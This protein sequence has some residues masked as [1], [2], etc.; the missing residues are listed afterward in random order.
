MVKR[1]SRLVTQRESNGRIQRTPERYASQLKRA[2]DAILNQMRQPEWG[3]ACGMLFLH[4]HIT[5]EQFEAAKRWDA[6]AAA[7]R[8]AIAV[9]GQL[10]AAGTERGVSQHPP[11]PDS[12]EGS[13]VAERDRKAVE[14]FKAA[15]AVLVGVGLLAVAVVR[16][17]VEDGE[18]PVSF[19]QKLAFCRGC[20]ALSAHWGLTNQG[21]R[22]VR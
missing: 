8:K 16:A 11:D 9:P 21:K 19:E 15:H 13:I 3:T 22:N 5:A 1:K 14:R 4:E 17:T 20:D 6:C 18:Y 10:K 2:R 12:P 7:Y